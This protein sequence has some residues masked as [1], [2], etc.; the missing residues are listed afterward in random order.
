M[1]NIF[2]LTST[3]RALLVGPWL[4]PI[5]DRLLKFILEM[6]E[7][8]LYFVSK[9][10]VAGLRNPEN[11]LNRKKVK[12]VSDDLKQNV[13]N[14]HQHLI[15]VTN[16]FDDSIPSPISMGPPQF[17]IIPDSLTD[18]DFFGSKYTHLTWNIESNYSKLYIFDPKLLSHAIVAFMRIFAA[19]KI[20]VCQTV[21]KSQ[22]I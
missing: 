1:D 7:V 20:I 9:I 15:V 2:I 12:W 10:N 14:R 21:R 11:Y 22:C 19:E 3:S 8:L 18:D 4:I 6:I 16:S 5:L 13:Q 17:F